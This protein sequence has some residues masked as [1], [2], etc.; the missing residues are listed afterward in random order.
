ML[1]VAAVM[2]MSLTM[3]HE[4]RGE[5][6]PGQVAVG[7]VLYR[8]ADFNPKNICSETYRAAQ[9]EWTKKTKHVPDY[10]TLKPFVI[11]SE[12]IIR[13]QIKDSSKGASYFHSTALPN[14]W[15]MK[16]KVII[17]NHVFY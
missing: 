1:D 16:P 13:Q 12:K 10:K 7:Y 11:L 14:Q 6:I 3:Y 17:K 2:C 9:F 5:P 4:A 8:R 15:G